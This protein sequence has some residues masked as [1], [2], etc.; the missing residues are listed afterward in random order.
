MDR[1]DKD[2]QMQLV[3]KKTIAME[4]RQVK[5][6]KVQA[7]QHMS[8]EADLQELKKVHWE[9]Q[10]Y[11]INKVVLSLNSLNALSLLACETIWKSPP[12]LATLSINEYSLMFLQLL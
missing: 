9:W 11:H 10:A 8:L 7:E 4:K 2:V 5:E 3:K 12:D 6:Q 1:A